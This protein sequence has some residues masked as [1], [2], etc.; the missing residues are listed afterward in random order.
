MPALARNFVP[1][2]GRRERDVEMHI[3]VEVQVPCP[4]CLKERG[5]ETI[6]IH[7]TGTDSTGKSFTVDW[8]SWHQTEIV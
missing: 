6:M 4:R 1:S 3:V 8:C 7:Y 5:T 2:K